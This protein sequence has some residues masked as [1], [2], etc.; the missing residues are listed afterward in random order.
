MAKLYG[1]PGKY[2]FRMAIISFIAGLSYFIIGSVT[3]WLMVVKN[4]NRLLDPIIILVLVI[5]YGPLLFIIY[6][7]FRKE[8]STSLKF[9]QG[10][11]GESH[12]G[13][14]IQK[15][16][17]DDYTIYRNAIIRREYGDI[18]FILIGPTGIFILEVKSHNGLIKLEGNQLIRNGNKLEKD[19]LKQAR[20]KALALHNFLKDRLQVDI[21]VIPVVVFANRAKMNFGLNPVEK[22]YVIQK[23]WL[24]KLMD[25]FPSHQFPVSRKIIED[26]LAIL[27][28]NDTQKH[29]S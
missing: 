26:Q 24:N 20:G 29:D 11:K 18:D 3:A 25:S 7:L 19:F 21:F 14:E 4:G 1:Q 8:N 17:S 2:S 28:T 27:V 6:Y 22:V 5:I 13:L 23:Y 12:V 15:T 10:L 16:L 9:I